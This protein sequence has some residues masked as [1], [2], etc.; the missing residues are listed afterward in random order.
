VTGGAAGGAP[1]GGVPPLGSASTGGGVVAATGGLAFSGGAPTGGRDTGGATA[2]GGASGGQPPA[3]GASTGG[4]ATGGVPIGG[5]AAGGTATGGTTTGGAPAGGAVT[6]G[7][8]TGGW[9]PGGSNSGGWATGG[10]DTGGAEAGGTGGAETGGG[11]ALGGAETGGAETG[12]TGGPPSG[13]GPAVGGAATELCPPGIERTLTVARD[14]SGDYATGQGA[15]DS[16]PNGSTTPTR[17]EVRAG[18]YAEKLTIGGRQHLCLVGE[19][20]ATTILTYGDSAADGIGTSDSASTVVSAHD[21]SAANLTFENSSALGDGQ[22]VA[23][24]ADGQRE[25]FYR[26]R[27]VS[28]QDT[29][30]N[31]NGSQ[32]FRDCYV[33]GNTDY[34]FGAGTAVF[35]DCTIHSISEGTAV[36]APRTDA[37]VPYG[38]VF[39]GGVFTADPSV[40]TGH[41]HLARPWGP[42]AAAT[43]LEVELGAH[44]AAVGYT[45]M[46]ENTLELT[47]FY[48]YASTGP[49]ANPT[50]R[51]PESR[52]L[53]AEEAAAYTLPTILSGWTPSYAVAP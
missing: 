30:Y 8:P 37:A 31:R 39:R 15:I 38:I 47:R 2:V 6:G 28:Y 17:I 34:I 32:Y 12:G 36:T 21:F 24:R 20:P 10:V 4:H 11:P 3:G 35:D 14:G 44:I 29:L 16:I 53:T 51:A 25:Q 18:R 49:G 40:R 50:A 5:S 48:E 7:A 27:F 41:V 9:G 43:F 33:Q 13:G 19:D 45:T 52:Q 23:L 1:V 46:S 22:A 26:C 42:Y